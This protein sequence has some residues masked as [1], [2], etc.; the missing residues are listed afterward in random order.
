MGYSFLAFHWEE[1]GVAQIKADCSRQF[2]D[3]Y[4]ML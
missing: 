1:V 3:N 2:I 4:S